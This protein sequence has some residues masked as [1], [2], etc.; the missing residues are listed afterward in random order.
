M[1]KTLKRMEE[2]EKKQKKGERVDKEKERK[3]VERSRVERIVE[4]NN[5]N[6]VMPLSK[7]KCYLRY[8]VDEMLGTIQRDYATLVEK[9]GAGKVYRLEC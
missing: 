2:F 3:I 1:E 5:G 8:D 9:K 7:I 6:P 4:L